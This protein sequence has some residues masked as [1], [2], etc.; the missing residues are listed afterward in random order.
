MLA[1]AIAL[2]VAAACALLSPPLLAWLP[3][4]AEEPELRFTDLATPRFRLGLFVLIIVTATLVLA[5]TPPKLWL[6]WA[7]LAGLGSLLALIDGHSGFLP[8][9]LN[10]LALALVGLG[11][12][13]AAWWSGD[14]SSTLWALGGGLA[15]T[16]VYT[17]VWLISRGQLGFG[18]VR[19]AGL[20]GAATGATSPMVL[21]WCFLLGSLVGAVWG[22][23]VRLRGRRAFAYGPSMLIGAPLALIAAAVIAN[24]AS[25]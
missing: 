1:P 11:V 5:L 17:V 12:I 6:V 14:W 22:L 8:L 7:P 3:A 16:A 9:R 18:D 20:L 24:V 4:P 25:N 21:L 13:V 15:A 19:L 23:A 10:Y 2:V